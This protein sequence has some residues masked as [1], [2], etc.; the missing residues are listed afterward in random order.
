MKNKVLVLVIILMFAVSAFAQLDRSIRPEP[1]PAPTINIGEYESFQLD[2][3]LKVFVVENDKQPRVSYS[4]VIDRDP[5]IEGE[6]AGYINLAGQLLR[7]GTETRSKAQIDEEIDF[8]GATLNTSATSV[9]GSSLKKHTEKLLDVMADVVLNAKFNE[10]ELEKLRKQTLS[11]LAFQKDD[12]GSIMS[13][14]RSALVY[15]LDHPYGEQVTEE[16]VKAVTL[17]I[18]EAYYKNYF[19]PNIAFLAIVGD[20]KKDEAKELVEEYFG[21]WKP[22]EVKNLE[23]PKPK[24]PLIRKVAV[25][26]RPNSVQSVINV[27]YPIDLPQ[28]NEDV[29]PATL[30]NT[31]LGGGIFS[32]RLIKNLREDKGYTYGAY[33]RLSSDEIVGSFYTYCEAR[34]SVT[35][36]AVTEFL[37]EMK[38][39]R[40]EKVDEETLQLIKNYRTGSFSRSLESPQTIASFAL[41]TARYDLPK[42][43]YKNY[44]KRLNAVTADEILAVSKKYIKPNNSYVIVV[45]NASE[46]ADDL[47]K[48]SVNGKIDYYDIYGNEYDPSAKA[49]PEGLT[50][51][52]VIDKYVEAVGGKENLMKVEDVTIKMTGKVQNFDINITSYKK[53]PNKSFTDVDAGVMKQEVKFD[54]EKGKQSGMGQEMMMEGDMLEMMKIQS[55]MNLFLKYDELGITPE[56]T[57]V[58]DVNGS[59]AY[60]VTLTLPNG[61]NMINYYDV[62]SGLKVRDVSTTET[63]QG[64]FT[65]TIDFSDYKEVDGVMYP[66]KLVQQMGMGPMEL[67]V[68]SV[69]VNTGLDDSLFEVD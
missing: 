18:C 57:G 35:D 56:L 51:D 39:M 15:G 45:G 2:N 60:E 55:E 10:E 26:D 30:A 20:I 28:G 34:N 50:A 23:Y 27:A 43:Y 37:H 69:E 41:N 64:S 33:S 32:A 31:I 14:V 1:G 48:F 68:T 58:K 63:P 25:V 22:S 3:G 67:E 44:L 46:V 16:T 66:F 42:D 40:T 47:K 38:R 29:I 19:V 9:F 61:K 8:I 12:P 5:I 49:I 11:G 52:D 24:A 53:V 59:D 21:K 6:K 7:T 65:Q 13:N 4:L 36:S 54:G 17:D 62:D